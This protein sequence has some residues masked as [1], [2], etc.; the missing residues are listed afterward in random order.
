MDQ[1]VKANFEELH[2]KLLFLNYFQTVSDTDLTLQWFWK[3]HY[4]IFSYVALIE[5]SQ[6]S[7]FLRTLR[8]A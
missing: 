6:A 1:E 2:T 4:N 8:S 5:K 3:K 7:V